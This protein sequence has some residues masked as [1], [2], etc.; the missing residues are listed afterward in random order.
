MIPMHVY[1]YSV[2]RLQK[3]GMVLRFLVG[4]ATKLLTYGFIIRIG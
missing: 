4:D 3:S 2:S 1:N